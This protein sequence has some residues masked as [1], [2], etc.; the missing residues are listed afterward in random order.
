MTQETAS[1]P[2]GKKLVIG[3]AIA[4]LVAAAIVFLFVLPAEYGIDPLGTGKATGLS[5][6]AEAGEMTELERGALREGTVLALVDGEMQ[7]DRWE[8]ELESFSSVEFKY[9]LE[10]GAPLNFKWIASAPLKYDMHAHP[11]EGGE[12]L[13]ESYSVDKAQEMQGVYIAP[14]TGIHGWY[15]QNQSLDNVT[16]VL[17]AEGV[18][19]SST[20]FDQFGEHPRAIEPSD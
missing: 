3:S 11:F 9:T 5:D 13:T 19:E 14:F 10:E 15:W 8:I 4:A 16:L 18:M 7:Q 2:S 20:I 17:D 6:L 1:P 12:E